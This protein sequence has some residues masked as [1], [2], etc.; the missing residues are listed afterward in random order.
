MAFKE[1]VTKENDWHIVCA[2][3]LPN[4][5]LVGASDLMFENPSQTHSISPTSPRRKFV[6]SFWILFYY[7][8]GAKSEEYPQKASTTIL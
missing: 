7:V 3:E 5:F 2:R 1:N 6:A 8:S 4:N